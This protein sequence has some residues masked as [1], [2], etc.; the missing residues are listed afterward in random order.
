MP[1]L[2]THLIEPAHLRNDDFDAFYQARS[3]ALASL[4]AGAMR[5][6]VVEEA[7]ANEAEVDSVEADD[8][9]AA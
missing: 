8:L 3:K 1:F 2:R 6:P 7:G 5:K 9:E 4:V